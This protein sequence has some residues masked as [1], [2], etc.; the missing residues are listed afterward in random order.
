MPVDRERL[1]QLAREPYSRDTTRDAQR[2]LDRIIRDMPSVKRSR[3]FFEVN[4]FAR[5]QGIAGEMKRDPTLSRRDAFLKMV[6][7]NLGDD[8]FERAYGPT[9]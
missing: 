1:L 6:R 8:L 7:A 9:P 5:E 2:A 3:R 4:R